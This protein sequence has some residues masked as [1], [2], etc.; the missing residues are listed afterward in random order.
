M[1]SK[2]ILKKMH[3]FLHDRKTKTSVNFLYIQ[4]I[5]NLYFIILNYIK[6]SHYIYRIDGA[7]ISPIY[8]I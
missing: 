3:T 8:Q 4:I 5:F 7:Y 6:L 2:Y 1:L